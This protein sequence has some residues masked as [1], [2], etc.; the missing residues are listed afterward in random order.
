MKLLTYMQVEQ[1]IQDNT[2]YSVYFKKSSYSPK[3][4]PIIRKLWVFFRKDSNISINLFHQNEL[5][6]LVY[7][8]N[9]TQF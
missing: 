4:T 1:L 7:D 5:D 9:A 8:W 3:L 6:F 2:L